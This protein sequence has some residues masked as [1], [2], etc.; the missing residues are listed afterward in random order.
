MKNIALLFLISLFASCQSEKLQEI[1]YSKNILD[2]TANP[3]NAY[4]RTALAFSDQGAWFAYGLPEKEQEIIGFSG[5]FLMTEQNGVWASRALT[6]LEIN[7]KGEK[8]NLSNFN[9]SAN[10]YT[11]H[12][13]Q[14]YENSE[15]RVE[16]K[17]FFNAFYQASIQTILTN[18]SEEPKELEIQ[19]F[20]NHFLKTLHFYEDHGSIKINSDTSLAQAMISFPQNEFQESLITD[21]TYQTKTKKLILNSSESEELVYH[22][23]FLFPDQIDQISQIEL[24]VN[25]NQA[26]ANRVDEKNRELGNIFS[27]M[28]PEFQQ[29]AYFELAAKCHLT[30]QNNWRKA[31]GELKHDGLF[32]SYH[33]KW[34]HGFWAWDSWK[35]AV[36]LARYNPE[37]AKNQ[38]R[39]MYDYLEPNGFIPD[40]IYRDT[41]I[42]KHNYRNTKPPLSAWAVWEVYKQD[43]DKSFLKEM[44]PKIK[45]Q[46]EWWYKNRDHDEDGICEY[47]S[48]DGTLIAA[49]WESGMDNAV[50]FDDSQ[51][52]QNSET[53]F[54]LDQESVDLN[55]YLIAE[56][57]YLNWI[58][59]SIDSTAFIENLDLIK[60]EEKLNQF[61]D[62][63]KGW[64]FDTNLE[65][66]AFIDIMGCEGWIPLWAVYS[67]DTEVLENITEN[68][69][70]KDNFNTKVPLQTLSANHPKF[71]PDGGYWRG[72]VW[73]DQSYFA[74][75]GLRSYAYNDEALEL[76]K[77]LIHNASGVLRK[78]ESIR[79]NYHP[80][81]GEGL[82]S[83]NFSWSAA[84]YLLLMM[85][86]E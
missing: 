30:L 34:F 76:T 3:E 86:D 40:C 2:F 14:V 78:G 6:Q 62:I 66:T 80:I 8:L 55:A 50:R 18:L 67:M 57:H 21:S 23:L 27:K 44:F 77:K 52:L 71:K 10:S 70:N 68:I 64:F 39:A 17:L 53:A 49:K 22:H 85:E 29:T 25:F 1:E 84:H 28:L 61:W 51:I 48:T 4:D 33:Y 45:K 69:M 58:S 37:L 59:E 16:Q 19:Y 63:K 13:V 35:H 60:L 56:K 82:E 54:S 41:T 46:H 11:S 24:D 12:L 74:I 65:G 32:P 15:L 31:A 75:M 79:E 72:P 7:I 43:M 42:E 20:G 36:A 9:Y 5:P 47:G 81:T 26:L 38:I 83:E 73:L